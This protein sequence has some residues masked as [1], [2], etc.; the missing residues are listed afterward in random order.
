M[1]RVAHGEPFYYKR[2]TRHLA[3]RLLFVVGSIGLAA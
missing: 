1:K 3:G 2:P